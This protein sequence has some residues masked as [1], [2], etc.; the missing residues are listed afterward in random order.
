MTGLAEFRAECDRRG[1]T[2][3]QGKALTQRIR[4]RTLLLT[5]AAEQGATT[6]EL[7]RLVAGLD[8]NGP[9]P[10]KDDQS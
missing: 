6:P 1:L 9:T 3:E 7:A 2:P 8:P 10:R 4:A 5:G